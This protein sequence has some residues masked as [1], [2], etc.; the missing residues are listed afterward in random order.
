MIPYS[1]QLIDDS[2]IEAV[3]SVLKSGFLTQGPRVPEFEERLCE[4][5]G[6]AHAVVMNSATSAL[7][8]AYSAMEL[9][10]DDEVILPPITFAATANMLCQL[11]IRPVFA[12]VGPDG[13]ICPASIKE[14]MTEKTR[15]VV[16][17]DFA[18]HP[19]EMDAIREIAQENGLRVISDS[20]HALGSAYRGKKV[21]TLADATIFSF[22]AI[23]PITT[24][25]GGALLTDDP[26]VAEKARRICSHGVVK[27]QLWNSEMEEL[28]FNFRLSDIGCALGISQ[29]QRLESFITAR[30][31]IAAYYDE[32]FASQE[33]FQTIAVPAE[34]RSTHHL[35]P[36]LLRQEL[37]CPKEEIF[38][39][40]RARGIGVQVHYKPVYRYRYYRELLG[41]IV[42]PGAEAFYKAELSIPCH[43]AMSGDDAVWVADQLLEVLEKHAAGRCRA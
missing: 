34:S 41:E 12:D 8:A 2:D 38:T 18:G 9:Q 40:L 17:V 30:E 29:L 19:V 11:G 28:G 4:L 36:I 31:K 3:V 39:E 32:R 43:Q 23:K 10:V 7:Y 21:G 15:A 16:P 26:E 5:T 35:Y 20:S 27:K 14:K 1:R 13:A 24:G 42:L 33:W 37:W 6:A 25:E 22:H